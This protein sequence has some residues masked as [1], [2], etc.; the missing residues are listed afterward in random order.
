M[1]NVIRRPCISTGMGL[2]FP[3]TTVC[4]HTWVDATLLRLHSIPPT[5]RR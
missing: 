1:P 5:W 2:Q 4:N 3:H